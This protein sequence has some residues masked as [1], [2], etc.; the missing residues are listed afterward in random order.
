MQES[1]FNP[2]AA[3]GAGAQGLMQ[4]V[5]KWHPECK[6][7]NDPN[8]AI[9]YAASYLAKLNRRYKGDWE[10]TIAAY[11]T[12]EGNLDNNIRKNGENWRDNLPLETK[13]YIADICPDVGIYGCPGEEGSIMPP[14]VT[15]SPPKNTG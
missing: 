12:G 3:S 1:T 10:K 13:N 9:P 14:T 8:E 2:S 5:P 4:I 7:P 15:P 11:N 6:N